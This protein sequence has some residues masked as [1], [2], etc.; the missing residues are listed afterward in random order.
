[1][2]NIYNEPDVVYRVYPCDLAVSRSIGDAKSKIKE[3]GGI[4]GCIIATPEVFMFDNSSNLDFIIMGCDGIFDNL[5]NNEKL[6]ILLGL[7]YIILVKK[8][9]MILIYYLWICVI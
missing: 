8:E 7:L 4:P 3:S 6:L 1:M 5:T 9:K 2:I